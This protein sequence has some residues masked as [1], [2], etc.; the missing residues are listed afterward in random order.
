MYQLDMS[1]LSEFVSCASSPTMSMT[2]VRFIFVVNGVS[3]MGRPEFA[4]FAVLVVLWS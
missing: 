3:C 4:E 2:V 1:F